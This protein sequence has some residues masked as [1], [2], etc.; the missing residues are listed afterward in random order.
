MAILTVNNPGIS[1]GST[2]INSQIN[3]SDNTAIGIVVTTSDLTIP[4]IS[5]GTRAYNK[6]ALG[7]TFTLTSGSLGRVWTLDNS[8]KLNISFIVRNG[9]VIT[10]T[11]F[12]LTTTGSNDTITFTNVNIFDDD[13]L[14]IIGFE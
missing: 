10:P 2:D 14:M 3:I 4:V 7:S 11:D 13:A 5:Y 6:T 12:T 8:F 1:I 9:A